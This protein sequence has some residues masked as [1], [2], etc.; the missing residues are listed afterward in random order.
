M[1]TRP[2]PAG[3]LVAVEGAQ[4]QKPLVLRCAVAVGTDVDPY[5]LAE[6]AFVP[7][8]VGH[9][10]ATSGALP[11]EGTALSVRGAQVSAVVRTG[12][13]LHVRVFNPTSREAT[14]EIDG[15]RGWL[16]DLRGAPI[17]PFDVTFA[18]RPHGIATAQLAEP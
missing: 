13:A 11:V 14:V 3:P 8:L 10:R 16:V 7:L 5:A 12:G 9:S 2:L 18:L 17:E 4:V 15:R 1:A 6:D